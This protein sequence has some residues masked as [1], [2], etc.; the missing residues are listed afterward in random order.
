MLV[1]SGTSGQL[2]ILHEQDWDAQA[3]PEWLAAFAGQRVVQTA[4]INQTFVADDYVAVDVN[5]T[6]GLSGWA[7]SGDNFGMR[8]SPLNQQS[9]GIEEY[10][11]DY[12]RIESVHVLKF[13]TAA[14]TTL[15]AALNPGDTQ[16][17]LTS[18]TGWSNEI[19]GTAESR[20]LAWYGYRDS[21]GTLFPDY[22]YTRNVAFDF[23][24][25]VWDFGAISFD[26]GVGAWRINLRSAWSGVTIAAGTAVRNATGHD[27]IQS[28]SI[29]TDR[30][31]GWNE[32]DNI[33][34]F[35]YSVVIGGGVWRNGVPAESTFRPGTQFIQP[36]VKSILPHRFAVHFGPEADQGLIPQVYQATFSDQ[37]L[38]KLNRSRQWVQSDELLPVSSTLST[39]IS[40][41]AA[42]GTVMNSGQISTERHSIGFVPY[43]ADGQAIESLHVARYGSA[44]DTTLAATLRPGDAQIVLTNATGWSNIDVA[45]TR[46]IAWYGYRDSTGTLYPNYSYTRN[47]A[48]DIVNGLWNPGAI[49][50]NVVTLRQPWSGPTLNSGTAVRNAVDG[51]VLISALLNDA[52]LPKQPVR[53]GSRSDTSSQRSAAD[54]AA[55][56]CDRC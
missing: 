55:A 23:L 4:G 1:D 52:T 5:K 20:S 46:G 37:S 17:L 13:G 39:T 3:A 2:N 51:D 14:D 7:R 10:D 47:V 12:L 44:V 16:I 53:H 32:R 6:Y 33:D 40:L 21:G 19:G 43:D 45:G 24:D 28:L 36:A 48:A 27:E 50:G 18:A 56:H 8:F 25:G 29:P 38:V 34:W 41:D 11:A 42:F 15:R 54:V 30:F 49:A 35:N 9:F 26:S 31:Y 22:T